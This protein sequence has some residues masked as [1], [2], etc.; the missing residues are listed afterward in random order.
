MDR[1]TGKVA[2]ITGANAGIGEAIG[3]V[4][5]NACVAYSAARQGL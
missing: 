4:Y 2:I 5:M 1:L 3:A